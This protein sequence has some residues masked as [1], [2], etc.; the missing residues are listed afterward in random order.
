MLNPLITVSSGVDFDDCFRYPNLPLDFQLEVRDVLSI[1]Q[2]ATMTL[3]EL[4]MEAGTACASVRARWYIEVESKKFE[5]SQLEY[6]KFRALL[7]SSLIAGGMG[8]VAAL[9]LVF[10]HIRMVIKLW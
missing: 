1:H 6:E 5:D 7:P 9:G 10:H 4:V 2:G 8:C 3:W